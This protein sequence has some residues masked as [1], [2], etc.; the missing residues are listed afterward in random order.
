MIEKLNIFNH[1]HI[2]SN[3]SNFKD[4]EDH[5]N[6]FNIVKFNECDYLKSECTCSY[7]LKNYICYH[8]VIIADK[9]KIHKIPVWANDAVV[10]SKG[11]KPKQATANNACLSKK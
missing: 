11:R 4:F 10:S 5:L 9:K 1:K 2:H 7:Y 6:S 3:F 8:I